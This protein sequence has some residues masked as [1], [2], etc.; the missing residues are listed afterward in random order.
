M[1]LPSKNK[2]KNHNPVE[3][4]FDEGKNIVNKFED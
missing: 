2:R 4:K 3:I 1:K